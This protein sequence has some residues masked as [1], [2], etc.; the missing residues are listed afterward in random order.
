MGTDSETQAPPTFASADKTAGPAVPDE[1]HHLEYVSPLEQDTDE[2]SSVWQLVCAN[3]KALAY[4]LVAN[5]GSLLFGYDLIVNGAV[6]ALPAFQF[7]YGDLIGETFILPALWQG[8]WTSLVQLGIMLGALASGFLQDRLGRRMAFGIGG[9]VSLLAT[10]LIYLSPT[11]DTLQARRLLLL[12]GKIILGVS[13]GILISTCQTYISEISPPKLRGLL[14]GLFAFTTALAQMVGITILFNRISILDYTAFQMPSALQWLWAGLAIIA[15]LVVPESPSWLVSKG[16]IQSAHKAH[17][18]LYSA[19]SD[20]TAAINLL[21]A[22]VEEEKLHNATSES[23]TYRECFQGTNSRR[24]LII[25]LANVLPQLV[26]VAL[27]ANATYFLIMAGMS[28]TRSLEIS[29]IGIGFSMVMTFVSWFT[30]AT[31]GRRFVI[32]ASCAGIAAMYLGMGI[33]GLF[34]TNNN[35]LT[36]IGV[37]LLLVGLINNLGVGSA[38]SVV[39][40][41]VSSVRLRSRS[42]GIGFIANALASWAFNFTVPYMFN[43]DEGNLGGK[44]GFVFAAF[45]IIGFVSSWFF[46]PETKTKTFAEIDYLFE[47]KTPTRAFK[48]PIPEV[49]RQTKKGDV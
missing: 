49:A 15:G 12:F 13:M 6:T 26:G 16:K 9:V 48:M 22:T 8:L 1:V 10:V 34:P 42:S 35:A 25:I 40:S 27:I 38:Y 47:R 4:S 46:V 24:T 39:A 2:S 7:T 11:L 29:Q 5:V 23:A 33:A 32:L 14:L 44:I 3:P 37:A 21:V 45:S 41:E 30:M 43:A 28:P 36:F 18:R 17:G 31:L 19:K 20:S